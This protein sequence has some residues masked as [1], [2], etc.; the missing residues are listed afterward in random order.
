MLASSPRA[1]LTQLL[2]LILQIGVT[3]PGCARQTKYPFRPQ[4]PNQSLDLRSCGMGRVQRIIVQLALVRILLVTP[5]T[6][7]LLV[8]SVP[9]TRDVP[10][11]D[12]TQTRVVIVYHVQLYMVQIG[13]I[14][15]LKI[16][17][18]FRVEE[19][20]SSRALP[21]LQEPVIE[22]VHTGNCFTVIQELLVVPIVYVL[23]DADPPVISGGPR[24]NILHKLLHARA[25]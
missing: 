10:L 11:R 3:N 21:R 6:Q 18:L 25:I 23:R 8:D 17:V 22:M 13:R 12:G 16:V 20:A 1:A 5:I 2:K 4:L 7:T 15:V 14:H 9:A 19:Y 24:H